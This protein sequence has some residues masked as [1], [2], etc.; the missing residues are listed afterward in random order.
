MV[1]TTLDAVDPLQMDLVWET[2]P[3]QSW[4]GQLS[5]TCLHFTLHLR[6]R[7]KPNIC[8]S[9]FSADY[10]SLSINHPVI[11][12]SIRS[13]RDRAL[14]DRRSSARDQG[15]QG[16]SDWP[17]Q[18]SS[19]HSSLSDSPSHS[20]C[21]CRLRWEELADSAA[22]LGTLSDSRTSPTVFAI[23]LSG[24]GEGASR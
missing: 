9:I 14:H 12:H 20:A 17:P 3:I 16:G 10:S 19:L 6:R 11:K 21:S 13:P 5:S 8:P 1:F 24:R 18:P 4:S 23:Y 2:L 7:N 22:V 15:H